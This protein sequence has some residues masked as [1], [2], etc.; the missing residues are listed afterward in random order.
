M[1]SACGVVK[2]K[3]QSIGNGTEQSEQPWEWRYFYCLHG[4][5]IW[6]FGGNWC[7]FF[8]TEIQNYIIHQIQNSSK[9]VSYKDLKE[10][11]A[12]LKVVYAVVDEDAAL[13]ARGT[14]SEHR[15][16][17][18]LTISWFWRENRKIL[19]LILS[20]WRSFGNRVIRPMQIRASIPA[21]QGNKG[22]NLYIRLMTAYLRCCIWR[23][24]ILP[25]K[26]AGR[27]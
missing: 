2:T 11:M 5:S 10:L 19:A 22:E 24:W 23:W 8:K 7:S 6:F 25:P 14:S 12:D 9:Y 15:D 18:Y 20:F 4:Q 21:S 1:F 13:V 27:C 3:V 16:K 17:K 26:G